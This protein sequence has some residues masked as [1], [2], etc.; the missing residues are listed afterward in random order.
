[1]GVVRGVVLV[2]SVY[3]KVTF[4]SGYIFQLVRRSRTD[5]HC[6]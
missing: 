5:F 2:C 3:L 1:M 4:I 6:C